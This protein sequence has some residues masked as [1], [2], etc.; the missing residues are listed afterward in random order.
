MDK[1]QHFGIF[2]AVTYIFNLLKSHDLVIRKEDRKTT[3]ITLEAKP[4]DDL[5]VKAWQGL[6]QK[7]EPMAPG[8]GRKQ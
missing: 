7:R 1:Q 6:K 5:L 2:F 4:V 8:S 3:R